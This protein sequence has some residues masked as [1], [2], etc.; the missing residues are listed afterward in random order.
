[1]VL[2]NLSQFLVVDD[3]NETAYLRLPNA[4]YWWHWY[5]S[6]I[7]ANAT[8]LKLLVRAEPQGRV[9]AKLVKYLLNN[10]SHAT[11]WNSTRDTALVVES[12][13]EYIRQTDEGAAEQTV[14]VL[15]DGQPQ[16]ETRLT[17]AKL[18]YL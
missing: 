1:M 10:R 14:T 7:E 16:S 2:R 17:P 3:E 15:Y 13:A 5:G 12:L 18:V 6:D 11:Y 8:Y 9:A 4:G